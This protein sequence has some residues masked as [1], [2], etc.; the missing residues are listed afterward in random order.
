MA[1]G[2]TYRVTNPEAKRL[3]VEQDIR[4][5]AEQLA[6]A[7]EQLTPHDT[8]RMAASYRVE[9]GHEP[10]TSIVTNDAPYARYVEYGTRYM[11]ADAPLGRAVAAARASSR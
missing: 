6:A 9:P 1:S 2:A 3:A 7:A 5:A 10:G 8:G 4:D 11:R